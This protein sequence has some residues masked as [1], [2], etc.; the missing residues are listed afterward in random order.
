VA[1]QYFPDEVTAAPLFHPGQH[2]DEGEIAIRMAE[3][4]RILGRKGRN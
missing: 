4:D 1:Q 2:G 3:I